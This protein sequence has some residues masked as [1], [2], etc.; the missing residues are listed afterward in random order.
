MVI[1]SDVESAARLNREIAFFEPDL[2]RFAVPDWETL[3]YDRFSP[4]QDIVSARIANLSRLPGIQ[5]GVIII[6]VQT[7]MHRF[8]PHAWLGGRAFTLKLGGRID[9]EAFRLRLDGAGYRSCAQV[10]EHGD[11]AVRGSLIDLF[12]MGEDAPLRIDLFDD[13]VESLRVFNVETQRSMSNV[14]FIDVLPAREFPLDKVAIREFRRAW[15]LEFEGRSQDCSLY[16]DVS[17]GFAP[18]GIEYYLP[19]FFDQL[20]LITDYFPPNVAIVIEEGVES[21][22]EYFEQTVSD[23]YEVLC[24]DKERPIV[25]FSR[26]FTNYET[27]KRRLNAFPQVQVSSLTPS[28]KEPIVQF[29]LRAPVRVP[30]NA[31]STEPMAVLCDHIDRTK[32]RVLFVADSLGRRETLLQLLSDQK[33]NPKTFESWSDFL[34]ADSAV[35]IVVA[36]LKEGAE[37]EIP[38]LSILTEEQLF[39]ERVMQRR[40]RRKSSSDSDAVVRNLTELHEGSPVVHEYHGVGRYRQLKFLTVGDVTNEFIKIEYA[41]GDILY[42]PVSALNLISR[43][44]GVDPDRAPLHKLGSG[45][46]DKA[47]KKAVEKIHDVA[48]E[49]LELNARRAARKGHAFTLENDAYNAFVQNFP[50]EE[51]AD[52]MNAIESVIDDMQKERPMDRLI[53]G[54]VGFGKTE[55]AMR[56]AFLAVN[57]GRQV[58][59]L[60]PTTLLARQH[61][62]TFKDRFADWPVRIEQLSRFRS[63]KATRETL[64]GLSDG[65]VDIVVGTHKLLARDI[66]FKRLGLLVVDEEHR[67]GVRQKERIKAL[68]ND[69]D[70][71]TL[72]ATPI[73]RTL[74]LALSGTRELSIIATAPSKRIAIK[75]FVREWSTHLLREAML[76]EISRGGQV[77]FVHNKVETIEKMATELQEIIPEAR[78]GVVHGQMRERELERGMLDFYHGRCNVLVCS[79]IIETGIDV[80][81][82]NTMIINRADKFGLA[83]LYQLR[84]RVGRWHHQAYAYMVVP[85]RKAMTTDAIKRLEAIESLEELG[86]G[87][88]L[89]THDLEIRGAG[90]ILGEEQSGH[91][92]EIGFGLYSE[93]LKRTVNALKSGRDIDFDAAHESRVDIELHIPALFPED[94][95]PDVHMRLMLYK[96][97]AS[98]RD[99]GALD[100][101]REEII[102]RFGVFGAPVQNLFRI[103]SVRLDAE[104]LGIRRIDIGRRSGRIEFYSDPNIDPATIIQLVKTVP[105]YSF[106]G[107]EKLRIAKEFQDADEKFEE[108]DYLFERLRRRHAA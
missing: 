61:F 13:E 56:A 84:G 49:L 4:Y 41:D 21:S 77:Y 98:V 1:A 64:N 37:V 47:R 31:R 92:Q 83:Q 23:R 85:H 8:T 58:A 70:I 99:L 106:E 68:R 108:L 15:R 87:F 101:L 73:P 25:E 54:D 82:A 2:P 10:S 67:F 20:D 46:W 72:T 105:G 45:Q 62:D 36:Q 5:R 95:L 88:S 28:S 16:R 59:I 69:V 102:D 51:T 29:G 24:A 50:F 17:E 55:V 76:R 34:A 39:G 107:G 66:N 94:Y 96:Q 11:Y 63:S 7:A 48:A 35:G 27:I 91:I 97:I 81:N 78:L 53:C 86:V 38:R 26:M 75:T 18:A 60:V 9:R 44:S 12:P 103:T 90:E 3:P 71:L 40:R 80:P 6:A 22:A 89:A 104:G 65:T 74:N 100:N 33:L 43:Y 57:D 93:L 42:V 79:A 30:V 32:G 19:L 14:E 52:Q